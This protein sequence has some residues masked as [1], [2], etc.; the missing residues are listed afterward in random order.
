MSDLEQSAEDICYCRQWSKQL[1]R[2]RFV[3]GCAV[4]LFVCISVYKYYIVEQM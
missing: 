3:T 4:C 2:W 1:D